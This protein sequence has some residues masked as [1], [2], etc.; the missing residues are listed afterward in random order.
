MKQNVYVR[1]AFDTRSNEGK[2]NAHICIAFGDVFERRW[3][4][5]RIMLENKNKHTLIML[6]MINKYSTNYNM[7]K[8]NFGRDETYVS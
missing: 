1:M 4:I 7:L 8:Y 6:Y 2:Q 3:G 5:H